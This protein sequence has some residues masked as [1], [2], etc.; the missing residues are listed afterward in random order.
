MNYI[1]AKEELR[2]NETAYRFQGAEY[3][4]VPVSFFWVETLPGRGPS[5]HRHPYEEV[6]IVQHGQVLFTVGESQLKVNGGKIVIAP[7]NTPHKFKNVGKEPLQM[8]SIHPNKEVIQ[9]MLE[10]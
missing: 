5:L 1:I 3:G 4:G 8:V 9:E 7:A 10:E 6:F 2:L